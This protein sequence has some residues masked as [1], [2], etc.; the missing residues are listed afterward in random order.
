MLRTCH[1]CNLQIM[2]SVPCCSLHLAA[3]LVG[4]GSSLQFPGRR[5][6]QAHSS[7]TTDVYHPDVLTAVGF[8]CLCFV[9]VE[10]KGGQHLWHQGPTFQ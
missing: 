6:K 4:H 7:I 2:V 3:G 1:V 10:G 8:A 9:K 5:Q